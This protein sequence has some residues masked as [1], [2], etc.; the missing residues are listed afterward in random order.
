MFRR[1]AADEAQ[2]P[3]GGSQLPLLLLPILWNACPLE[4]PLLFSPG[5]GLALAYLISHY[6]RDHVKIYLEGAQFVDIDPVQLVPDKIESELAQFTDPALGVNVI[7]GDNTEH[8]RGY[9]V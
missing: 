7:T 3:C 1:R 8:C 9:R 2:E 5:E 6:S 4:D